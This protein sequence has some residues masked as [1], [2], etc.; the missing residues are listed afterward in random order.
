MAAASRLEEEIASRRTHPTEWRSNRWQQRAKA[1]RKLLAMSRG[2][3][4]KPSSISRY[5]EL[6]R[7]NQRH[8]SVTSNGDR[9]MKER[10]SVIDVAKIAEDCLL[11]LERA[12]DWQDLFNLH[13]YV[14][15]AIREA[16]DGGQ[17]NPQQ[18]AV[19]HDVMSVLFRAALS[20]SGEWPPKHDISEAQRRDLAEL[21]PMIAERLEDWEP[22]SEVDGETPAFWRDEK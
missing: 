2:L 5:S 8:C 12:K 7:L 3:T 21:K 17:C 11:E 10:L 19:Y 4:G 20:P 13:T 14:A 15:D 16:T 1:T 6:S 22:L 18:V 9:R